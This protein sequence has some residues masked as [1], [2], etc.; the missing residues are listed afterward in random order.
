MF[1]SFCCCFSA[2]PLPLP[3]LDCSLN[4]N[5]WGKHAIHEVNNISFTH[6]SCDNQAAVMVHWM[7]SPLG[8]PPFCR[9]FSYAHKSNTN[10]FLKL[11]VILCISLYCASVID[12][13]VKKESFCII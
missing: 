1:L 11:R 4:W 13:G 3:H 6:L 8:E 7:P 2:P 5:P 12:T 9:V 10:H